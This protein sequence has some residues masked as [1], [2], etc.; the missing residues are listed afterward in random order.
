MTMMTMMTMVMI[1]IAATCR[2]ASRYML[3]APPTTAPPR[4]G[5]C[6]FVLSVER[7]MLRVE[8]RRR[9]RAASMHLRGKD[10]G[11]ISRVISLADCKSALSDCS[12]RR[13]IKSALSARERLRKRK[14]GSGGRGVKRAAPTHSGRSLR[15]STQE[16][17]AI[18][19]AH[20]VL[21]LRAR[22]RRLASVRAKMGCAWC[23]L[24]RGKGGEGAA[25]GASRGSTM[26]TAAAASGAGARLGGAAA[27]GASERVVWRERCGSGGFREQQASRGYWACSSRRPLVAWCGGASARGSGKTWT[28]EH[29]NLS[30]RGVR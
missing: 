3:S 30:A 26:A 23:G 4:R 19:F 28:H 5:V 22:G 25:V 27:R 29:E 11:K 10:R 2:I 15:P 6:V 14:G 18:P 21:D 1:I 12:T 24:V 8:G 16:A 13:A 17:A 20:V 7:C 9:S